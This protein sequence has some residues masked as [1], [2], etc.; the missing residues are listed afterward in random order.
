MDPPQTTSANTNGAG[1]SFARSGPRRCR[2]EHAGG[3]PY[4]V[5]GSRLVA[6]HACIARHTRWGVSGICIR[7]ACAG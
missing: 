6:R 1:R 5:G 7:S 3:A 2:H 4:S